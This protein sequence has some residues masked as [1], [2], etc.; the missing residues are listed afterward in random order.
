MSAPPVWKTLSKIG[1]YTRDG[2]ANAMPGHDITMV[3]LGCFILA[4]GWF[5]FNPG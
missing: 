2:S 3:L 4:F 5:G 1:K